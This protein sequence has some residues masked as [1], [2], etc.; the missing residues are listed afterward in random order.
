MVWESPA[1]KRERLSSFPQMPKSR[2]EVWRVKEHVN[3]H[4]EWVDMKLSVY[5]C[6]WVWI[7]VCLWYDIGAKTV[8]RCLWSC[9]CVFICLCESECVS[10]DISVSVHVCGGESLPFTWPGLLPSLYRPWGSPTL[11]ETFPHCQFTPN[12]FP[13]TPK[14]LSWLSLSPGSEYGTKPSW[15]PFIILFY[16]LVL[17]HSPCWPGA[18]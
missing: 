1:Q 9:D 7:H 3:T 17:L 18:H 2:F 12:S 6:I 14:A 13:L 4:S 10:V 11:K 16:F 15:E 5:V 8:G